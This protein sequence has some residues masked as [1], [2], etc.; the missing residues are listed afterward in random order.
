V[1]IEKKGNT[2]MAEEKREVGNIVEEKKVEGGVGGEGGSTSQILSQSF[3]VFN[4]AV[5]G[6]EMTSKIIVLIDKISKA[7][8]FALWERAKRYDLTSTQAHILLYLL[9][10]PEEKR[11]VSH[12]AVEFG[13]SKPTISRAV[14]TL[15]EKGLV[16]KRINEKNRRSHILTLT[17]I[18][19]DTAMFVSTFANSIRDIIG[20]ISREEK[21]KI[22]TSLLTL[23]EKLVEGKV[24]GEIPSCL[25]CKYFEK[26]EKGMWC[27]KLEI[28]LNYDTIKIDCPYFE[29]KIPK[30]KKRRR[31]RKSTIFQ[32]QSTQN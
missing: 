10:N 22:V 15:M 1:E 8:E 6:N 9:F 29:S 25:F 12:M 14:D 16:S 2:N 21:E 18:G 24:L 17:S 28:V 5:H 7:M 26:S 4:P 32:E 30:E 20:S 23:V 27:S 19:I 3:S 31:R 13:V 11:N